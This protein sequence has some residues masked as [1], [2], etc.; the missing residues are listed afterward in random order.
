MLEHK[1][2]WFDG[3]LN[4]LAILYCFVDVE[5]FSVHEVVWVLIK[6]SKTGFICTRNVILDTEM[7]FSLKYVNVVPSS[8]YKF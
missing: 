5:T 7:L 8:E 4:I 6:S 3:C 1:S 2:E